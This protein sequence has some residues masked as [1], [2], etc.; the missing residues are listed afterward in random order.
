MNRRHSAM[1]AVLAIIVI[2]YT[3]TTTH[4]GQQEIVN[5]EWKNK[6]MSATKDTYWHSAMNNSSANNLAAKH[7]LTQG[8]ISADMDSA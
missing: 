6:A 5:A 8:A 1:K 2:L 4:A 3:V 7:V